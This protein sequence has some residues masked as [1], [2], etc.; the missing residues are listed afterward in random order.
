M[1]ATYQDRPLDIFVS[2]FTLCLQT[3]G[4]YGRPDQTGTY[5]PVVLTSL[6]TPGP[7]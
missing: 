4:N 6:L 1:E 2:Y 3:T 7:G 5:L